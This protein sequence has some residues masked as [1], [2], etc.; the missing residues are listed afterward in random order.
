MTI[1]TSDV[2]SQFVVPFI[3]LT[4][5]S[6]LA[7]IAIV[8]AVCP[9]ISPLSLY[10]MYD[11]EAASVTAVSIVVTHAVNVPVIVTEG[12]EFIMTADSG[13]VCSHKVEVFVILTL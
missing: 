11:G 6:P 8:D 7:E 10:Q 4:L 5:Y 2:C 9:L 1:D 13:E 12:K 3:T